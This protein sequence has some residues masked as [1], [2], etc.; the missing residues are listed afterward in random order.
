MAPFTVDIDRGQRPDAERG[1]H[2]APAGQVPAALR[3][4]QRLDPASRCARRRCRPTTPRRR[5]RRPTAARSSRRVTPSR[6]ASA[7]SRSTETTRNELVKRAMTHLLPATADSTAPTVV[8]WKYP[9]QNWQGTPGRPGR[10]RAHRVRRARRHEGGP[11]L[12]QR[13]AVHDRA[14]RIPFQFRY[15]AAG[16]GRRHHGARSRPRPS[17]WPATCHVDP[18][19]VNVVSRPTAARRAPEPVDN[20]TMTGTPTVGST[21]T[22]VNGG[23]RNSRPAPRSR[24]CATAWSSRARPRPRTRDH[25]RHRP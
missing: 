24:G 2:G 5:P 7:S 3:N 12:R 11:L 20:P 19:S 15:T 6:S 4:W 1:R 10:H 8:G 18:L 14:G 25:G 9:A 23:F 17:T 16:V 21:L 13:H 22:C